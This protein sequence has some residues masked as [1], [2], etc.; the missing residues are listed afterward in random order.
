MSAGTELAVLSPQHPEDST[1][2]ATRLRL[3]LTC[4]A[5]A[6]VGLWVAA[7][8]ATT[9]VM[10]DDATLLRNAEAVVTG[11]VTVVEAAD[12]DSGI[13][14]YVH[15]TVDR[16]IRG[17]LTPGPLVVRERGGIV[18]EREQRIFGA[19][20]F[21]V[22]ERVLLFLRRNA[23]GTLRT[24]QLA[25]G[26]YSLGTDTRGRATATRDLGHGAMVF[27]PETGAY[28]AAEP[29]QE[30]FFPML[31][32]LRHLAREV[33][34]TERSS[35][36]VTIPP[37]LGQEPT[38]VHEEFTYLGTP[39]R[40]F[41]PDSGQPVSYLVEAGGDAT[42]GPTVTRAAVDAAFDAWTNIPNASIVLQDGGTTG[43]GRLSPCGPNR[44]LF[45]DPYNEVDNPSGCSGIL[46]MGGYCT[47]SDTKVVNGTTFRRIAYGQI[48]FNNGWGGCR[49]WTQCNVA[50]V[51]THEIG[52]T[53]GFGHSG[54][55]SATMAAYAHFD[56]RCAALRA[57]DIAGAQFIYPDSAASPTATLTSVPTPTRT[58]T[59]TLT[60]TRTFTPTPVS[61]ATATPTRTIPP[62]ATPTAAGGGSVTVA[63][64]IR[65]YANGAPVG[66]TVV[67]LSDDPKEATTDPNGH[68]TLAG[69]TP[70]GFDLIPRK[71]GAARAAVSALDAAYV[72]QASVGTRV[73]TPEQA[74][75]ADVT[76]NGSV[77]ALDASRIL[78]LTVG[79]V[80]DLPIVVT[81][82]SDWLFVPT[83]TTTLNQ[84]SMDPVVATGVCQPGCIRYSPL[85][86]STVGQDFV[87][88]AFGD[89]TGNWTASSAAQVAGPVPTV[90][91][92]P[93]TRRHSGKMRVPV[94][95]SAAEPFVGLELTL[96]YTPS[97]LRV[98]SARLGQGL[99]GGMVVAH[100]PTPGI[101]GLAAAGAAPLNADGRATIV[102][103]FESDGRARSLS[104]VRVEEVR[105]ER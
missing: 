61:T 33:R 36:V 19:P 31:K 57:D 47:Y 40:W 5:G 8:G 95:V 63:G 60:P 46:A 30:P 78:Q 16:V 105:V 70:H 56:G 86:T 51:A 98:A 2:M 3:V 41:E 50:E 72:L 15:L 29:Q 81:C 65:Y 48:M 104:D 84:D 11:T 23:D 74:L 80:T 35:P 9:F 10:M 93:A 87:A 97:T 73:L 82:N 26:K 100:S 94:Y 69:V 89:V 75:A 38:E 43:A 4:L 67:G 102:L 85:T 37:E 54:D 76:G 49:G 32:R 91:F 62:T 1:V 64:T 77:G 28:V 92:G 44:I 83:A 101:V 45:N 99:T 24:A 14:T 7:A 21:W 13:L 25:M 88:I 59:P 18:D 103:T 58:P 79:A 68:F 66:G 22:G 52:H 71:Q 27:V 90:T 34:G 12:T 42:L 53:I 55:T 17:D 39:S 20:Q 6:V 96:R